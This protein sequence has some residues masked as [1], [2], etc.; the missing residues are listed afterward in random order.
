MYPVELHGDISPG[1][2]VSLANLLNQRRRSSEWRRSR[3][4]RVTTLASLFRSGGGR[5]RS[6]RRWNSGRESQTINWTPSFLTVVLQTSSPG[7]FCPPPHSDG[8]L[9]LGQLTDP[10]AV[11]ENLPLQTRNPP[12]LLNDGRGKHHPPL[13]AD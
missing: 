6:V 1:E 9:G 4:A 5:S 11:L 7:G 10:V 13:S 12:L 8:F 3:S 2:S